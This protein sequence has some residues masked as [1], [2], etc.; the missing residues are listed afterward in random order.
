MCH[1]SAKGVLDS[2]FNQ[3]VIDKIS[4]FHEIARNFTYSQTFVFFNNNWKV[5]DVLL[6][7]F[8]VYGRDMSGI[9]FFIFASCEL[10]KLV[11]ITQQRL[12]SHVPDK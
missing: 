4:V 10:L 1:I 5:L 2:N 12:I 6:L 8:K 3:A 11:N 7:F 9:Y